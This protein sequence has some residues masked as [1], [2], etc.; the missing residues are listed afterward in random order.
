MPAR[1]LASLDMLASYVPSR[2]VARF[3]RHDWPSSEHLEAATLFADVSGFTRLADELASQGMA[4]AEQLGVKLNETFGQIIEVIGDHGGEIVAFPGD[5]VIAVW[6][7]ER[8]VALQPNALRA[9]C[10]A[11]AVQGWAAKDARPS[12]LSLRAGVGAGPLWCGTVG[13]VLDRWRFCVGGQELSRAGEVASL[14]HPS[15][16]ALT[17]R[18]AEILGETVESS[19]TAGGAR[20]LTAAKDPP[21]RPSQVVRVDLTSNELRALVPSAVLGAYE[22]GDDEWMAE[23]RNTV[24]LFA[25]VGGLDFGSLEVGAEMDALTRAAQKEIYRFG[26]SLNEAVCDEKGTTLLAVW[27]IP[28]ADHEDCARR[29]V[30]C[31][32]ALEQRLSTSHR[33]RFGIASGRAFCGTRG[34][35]Q[36]REYAVIG[37]RVNLAARLMQASSHGVLVDDATA[38][39]VETQVELSEPTVIAVKGKPAPVVVRRALAKLAAPVAGGRRVSTMASRLLG[40][41]AEREQLLNRL[42]DLMTR[43]RG[44]VVAIEGEAGIGKSWLLADFIDSAS[45]RGVTVLA[46][47]SDAIDLLSPYLAWRTVLQALLGKPSTPGVA[48]SMLAEAGDPALAPLLAPLLGVHVPDNEQTRHLSGISRIEATCDLVSRLVRSRR[49]NL[50]KRGNDRVL[51]L[52]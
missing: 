45:E 18:A 5:A 40:R 16:V 44:G 2:L 13:G 19:T 28:G 22:S 10:C 37:D 14:V 51:I 34:N 6:P 29:A 47:A 8:G 9:A 49:R 27:G 1:D 32:L 33:V 52:S 31:A 12:G 30:E 43:D 21:G 46:G 15:Q 25:N 36:R 39:A 50:V 17:D 24:V 23:F 11:L 26:G 7:V 41:D 48:A 38:A 4:G 42:E 3:R 20:C 35:K